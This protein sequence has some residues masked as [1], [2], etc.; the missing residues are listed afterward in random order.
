[1]SSPPKRPAP[2]APDP[3]WEVELHGPPPPARKP[4]AESKDEM[5]AHAVTRSEPEPL[6][7]SE[8]FN[9]LERVTVPPPAGMDDHVA[10]MM[11]EAE[12]LEGLDDEGDRPT[13]LFEVEP[14]PVQARPGARSGDPARPAPHATKPSGR[15]ARPPPARDPAGGALPRR[16]TPPPFAMVPPVK[17]VLTRATP[18]PFAAVR[19]AEPE[20]ARA[21]RAA[22]PARALTPA[23]MRA[24]AAAREPAP[25]QKRSLTPAPVA[26]RPRAPVIQSQP[27]PPREERRIS[28]LDL[29]DLPAVFSLD[30][31]SL[32]EPASSRGGGREIGEPAPTSARMSAPFTDPAISPSLALPPT[33]EPAISPPFGSLDP[34]VLS[35]ELGWSDPMLDGGSGALGV[36]PASAPAPAP[37]EPD[38]PAETRAAIDARLAA[39]DYSRALM[40]VEAALATHPDHPALASS[41]ELC[42]DALYA[43]YLER[44]GAAGHIPR[45][46]VQRGALTGLTL[47]HRA[48]FLLSC[49]DGV[50]TVEEIIDVAAMPRLEAVRVLYELLQEGVIEMIGAR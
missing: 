46:A 12:L 40:L 42:R 37:A 1:M 9:D 34:L 35:D 30:G 28:S 18:P 41:A 15:D 43:R 2:P 11:A 49:V 23:P 31:L 47:D 29:E 26:V 8:D 6:E 17:P 39:G 20:P 27:P 21:P 16:A 50:S 48:G 36:P 24:A 7:L 22:S 19:P 25:P 4:R 3:N 14:P 38:L 32:D 5:L 44:L 33:S 10:R 45:L 13:P